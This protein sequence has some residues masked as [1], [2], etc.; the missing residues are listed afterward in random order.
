VYL[1]KDQLETCVQ[2]SPARYV[3]FGISEDLGVKA[4]LG[5]GGTDSIWKPFLSYFVKIQSGDFLD[6]E[7]ILLLGNF[8]FSDIGN[9]IKSNALN[10]EEEV[11][12]SRHAVNL[13][14]EEVET[15]V[16][17]ITSNKKSPIAI[18]GGQN[19]AFPLI[20]GSAKGLYKAGL[21]PLAQINFVNLDGQTDYRPMEGRHSGNSFRYADEDGY[22][23]KYIVVGVHE[24]DFPQNVWIDIVNNPFVDFI[25]YEDIFIHEKR[26]FIQA[27]EDAAEFTQDNYT[28]IELDLNIIKNLLS[29]DIYPTG[30]SSLHARQYVNYLAKNS[31]VAYLNISEGT[32]EM[33][34]GR[35]NTATGKLAGYLVPTLLKRSCNDNY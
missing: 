34:I 27:V 4:N 17:L 33:E 35:T 7:E 15:L 14:D 13:I 9:L 20:K 31:Q 32:T 1:N 21:L 19:N 12:A 8:D 11:A 3:I 6:G 16:K 29:A 30:I 25:T 5:V 10:Q 22:L 24:N 2:A 26:S 28:G 23:Q 18:G